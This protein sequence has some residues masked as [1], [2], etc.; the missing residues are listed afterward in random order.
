MSNVFR[1]CNKRTIP[2]QKSVITPV[3]ISF[4]TWYLQTVILIKAPHYPALLTADD[5][6][7]LATLHQHQC[8]T[9][10]AR[11]SS[12]AFMLLF[13]PWQLNRYCILI[14]Y[15]VNTLNWLKDD[16]PF[17]H[18]HFGD[19]RVKQHLTVVHWRKYF[20][21]A[22]SPVIVTQSYTKSQDVTKFPLCYKGWV[23]LS[24][25]TS[26]A[27]PNSSSFFSRHRH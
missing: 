5:R 11:A 8:F 13:S 26:G 17:V 7:I 12:T 24:R 6:L 21:C 1:N 15:F 3:S 14:K 16:H 20:L 19:P 25:V 23:R 18:F 9:L 10:M 22:E 4:Q 27:A 2:H